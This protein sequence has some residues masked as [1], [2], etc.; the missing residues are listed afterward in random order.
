[1]VLV[2]MGGRCSGGAAAIGIPSSCSPSDN[3]ASSLAII[4]R[5]R[6]HSSNT[7]ANL[8]ISS[9]VMVHLLPYHRCYRHVHKEG[10]RGA[11]FKRAVFYCPFLANPSWLG[12][13][14]TGWRVRTPELRRTPLPRTPVNSAGFGDLVYSQRKYQPDYGSDNE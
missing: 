13:N 6:S 9:S 14:G 5:M 8:P 12:R 7:D 3:A 1:M 10:D 11:S 4:T 2:S